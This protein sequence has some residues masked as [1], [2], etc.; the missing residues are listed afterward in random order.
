MQK[1]FGIPTGSLL[2]VLA[3][4][5]A[6][7]LAVV[8]VL[9]LR[10]SIFVRLAFR[11]GAR[12]RARTALIVVGLML[13]TTIVSAAFV[14]GDTMTTTIRSAVVYGAGDIDEIVQ[15][16]T[17]GFAAVAIAGGSTGNRWFSESVANYIARDA[18]ADPNVD[19]A[20]PAVLE[21]AAVQ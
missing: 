16:K 10:N 17:P 5:L 18:R 15:A 20:A 4:L 13:A 21:S 2:V 8:A 19:G 9:A 14:T 12:R 6:A 7:A 11:S 1:V 3:V